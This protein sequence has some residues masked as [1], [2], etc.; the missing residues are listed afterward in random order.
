VF[1]GLPPHGRRQ[2]V[3]AGKPWMEAPTRDFT[4][5]AVCRNAGML[6]PHAKTPVNYGDQSAQLTESGMPGGIRPCVVSR[7]RGHPSGASG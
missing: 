1:S 2:H 3:R 5:L 7:R 4:T 6:G